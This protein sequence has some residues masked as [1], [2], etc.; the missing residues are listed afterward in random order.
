MCTLPNIM[1]RI[2][3]NERKIWFSFILLKANSSKI[4]I[5]PQI[6]VHSIPGTQKN[7]KYTVSSH[8]GQIVSA[9][10]LGYY[11]PRLVMCSWYC[12]GT[13]PVLPLRASCLSSGSRYLLPK[14]LPSMTCSEMLVLTWIFHIRFLK[15]KNFLFT[16]CHATQITITPTTQKWYK[17][18]FTL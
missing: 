3:L 8:P 6:S 17:K 14:E 11:S 7:K 4:C 15:K 18:N 1:R 12:T 16:Q 13:K 9:R 2:K 5:L 10:G